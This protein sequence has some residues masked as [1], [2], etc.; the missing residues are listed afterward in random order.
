MLLPSVPSA[1]MRWR[2]HARPDS[3]VA[4]R[5][6]IHPPDGKT[7]PGHFVGRVIGT[8]SSGP[9][10]S[11]SPRVIARSSARKL[12]PGSAPCCTS[13][14][15]QVG[16]RT[17]ALRNPYRC[18]T[19]AMSSSR[20]A[21]AHRLCTMRA[22]APTRYRFTSS[23]AA[24]CAAIIPMCCQRKWSRRGSPPPLVACIQDM[25]HR[26]IGDRLIP[27]RWQRRCAPAPTIS[28]RVACCNLQPPEALVGRR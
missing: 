20:T 13:P 25:R 8:L 27:L 6:P 16:A 11:K 26:S 18:R 17:R 9:P 19:C 4:D 15:A 28:A 1:V 24:H 12:A 14:S 3:R 22:H 7:R 2:C 21:A 10:W 5:R 23:L